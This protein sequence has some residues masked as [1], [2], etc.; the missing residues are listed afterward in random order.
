LNI[1]FSDR[2]KLGRYFRDEPITV[3]C[4][5]CNTVN[6]KTANE[7][8]AERGGRLIFISSVSGFFIGILAM[9]MSYSYNNWEVVYGL[10]I[11]ILVGFL[12]DTKR[13]NEV[14]YFNNS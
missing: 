4:S 2:S 10:C 5:N 6:I 11:G 7:V 8:L 13:K 3:H 14:D 1:V 9:F 12:L